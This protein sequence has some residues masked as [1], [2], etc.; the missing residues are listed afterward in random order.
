MPAENIGGFVNGIPTPL[1]IGK[2]ELEDG[3]WASGFIC[4][5]NRLTSAK[6]I[7]HFGG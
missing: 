4:E 7:S 6:D 3:T 5:A 2:V 1:G